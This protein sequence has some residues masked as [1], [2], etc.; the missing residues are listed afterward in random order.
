MVLKVLE[1][2]GLPMRRDMFSVMK[3]AV[4]LFLAAT[5]CLVAQDT[6]YQPDGSQIPGPG[7]STASP[8]WMAELREWETDRSAEHQAWLDDLRRWNQAHRIP[9]LYVTHS[10]EE[11]LALGERVL[12]LEDGRII[13]QGTPHEVLSAPLQ[14]TVF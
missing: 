12:V 14:E 4:A 11:V 2:D 1:L 13:A 9:I 3:P 5:F 7:H 8:D 6:R 10:S